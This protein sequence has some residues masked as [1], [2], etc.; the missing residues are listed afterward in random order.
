MVILGIDPGLQIA[1]FAV[2]KKGVGKPLLVDYGYLKQSSRAS[3]IERVGVFSEFID[4]KIAQHT[5]THI[6]LETPFLGKNSQSFLKL[7][8][9]RGVLYERAYRNK[10]P[11]G[12]Y[13]PAHVKVTLTGYGRASKDQVARMVV[14]YFPG[15][16]IPEVYDVTD[17]IAVT[18]CGF[19]S[20]TKKVIA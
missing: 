18:L 11:L 4:G 13:A 14:H 20:Y 12:E 1:G 9:L 5:V 2:L 8:Y 17:A 3:L 16:C 7:G 6:A 19:W 15:L 10:I